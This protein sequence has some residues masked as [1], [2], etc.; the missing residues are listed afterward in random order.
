[1]TAPPPRARSPRR[2]GVLPR[3]GRLLISSDLHGNGA[4]FRALRRRFFE[5]SAA[6]SGVHWALLGD[7]VHGPDPRA[8]RDDP[9]LYDFDDASWEIVAGVADLRRRFPG[10]VHLVLGNHDHGHVGGPHTHKFYPDEVAQLEETLDEAQL[11]TLRALF[12]DALLLL[13]A[14]CGLLLA[15]GAP[16]DTLRSAHQLEQLSLDPRR[17]SAEGN[18]LLRTLLTSYGQPE[19]VASRVLA[20]V[21]GEL[22]L[23]LRVVVHGHDRDPAGFFREGGNQL[24]PVLFGAPRA[25]KRYLLVDLAGVYDDAEALVEGCELLHLHPDRA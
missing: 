18:A 19:A 6:D 8:R 14:P 21:G 11:A 13:L 24:C 23:D 22:G 1:M 25:Q 17:N 9:E 16:D 20:A 12:A 4:D 2:F 15:H 10:R 7:L 3:A 5:L